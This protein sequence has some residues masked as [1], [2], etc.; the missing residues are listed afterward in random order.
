MKHLAIFASGT[1]SNAVNIIQYFKKNG[2]AEIVLVLSDRK[3]AS[4]LEKAKALGIET[5]SF[6]PDEFYSND[7]ILNL[8]VSKKTDLIILAGFLKLVP[9][10]IIKRFPGK[11]INIHPALLPSYGGKGMYGMKV[12]DAISKA[13]EAETGITVHYVNENF[14]EGEIIF[15]ARTPLTSFDTPADI[16]TKVHALEMEWYPKVIEKLL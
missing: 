9:V 15:Q 7:T 14:D 11:I 16:F 6:T 10:K 3:N 5:R 4:V 8:L 2:L 12:H 13:G 1:G